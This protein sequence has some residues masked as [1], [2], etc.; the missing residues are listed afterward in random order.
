MDRVYNGLLTFFKNLFVSKSKSF[1]DNGGNIDS[2]TIK[3]SR[4]RETIDEY[5]G[6][7]FSSTD[8]EG[9]GIT[10]YIESRL[11]VY[12]KMLSQ[13]GYMDGVRGINGKKIDLLIKAKVLDLKSEVIKKCENE[14]SSIECKIE[15]TE[16][17]RNKAQNAY[18]NQHDYYEDTLELDYRNNPRKYSRKLGWFY[19]L[20]S[21]ILIVGDLPLAYKV[22]VKGFNFENLPDVFTVNVLLDWENSI[23]AIAL[24][25]ALTSISIYFKFIYDEHLLKGPQNKKWKN[26]FILLFRL[27]LLG[28]VLYSAVVF[29]DLRALAEG[30][31]YSQLPP[32]L[33]RISFILLSIILPM[34]GG[35][36]FSEGYYYL[37]LMSIKRDAKII[38]EEKGKELDENNLKIAELTNQLGAWKS[39][40]RWAES[41]EFL[42]VY[43]D[44]L[45]SYYFHFYE[46]GWYSSDKEHPGLSPLNAAQLLEHKILARK[47][48]NHVKI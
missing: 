2:I 35:V 28:I 17:I 5:F 39:S 36:F 11:S 27:S 1:E 30:T 13:L 23:F 24:V 38:L 22:V 46:H 32:S 34:L 42:S 40:L 33:V 4:F 19:L 41:T 25:L 8:R 29:G 18:N 14:I 9:E 31:K 21:F 12:A 45:H 48:S 47:I 43:Y 15:A 37:G 7:I 20:I 16:Q 26:I 44:Y 6:T 10:N 3:L